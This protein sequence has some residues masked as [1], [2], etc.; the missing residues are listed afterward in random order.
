MKYCRLRSSTLNENFNYSGGILFNNVFPIRPLNIVLCN[1]L[2][3]NASFTFMK[4]RFFIPYESGYFSYWP[5]MMLS[6]LSMYRSLAPYSQVYSPLSCLHSRS[7]G[8]HS[9]SL[10][11]ARSFYPKNSDLSTH[12]LHA[13]SLESTAFRPKPISMFLVPLRPALPIAEAANGPASL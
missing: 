1:E 5:T 8:N 7:L 13:V 12:L 4:E 2:E 6:L 9:F 3:S 10:S 11:V